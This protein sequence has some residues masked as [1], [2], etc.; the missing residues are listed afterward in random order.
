MCSRIES[1]TRARRRA[2]SSSRVTAARPG[3]GGGPFNTARTIGR[4]GLAPAF[5]GRLSQDSFGDQLRARLDEDGVT[6]AVPQPADV[7]TTLAIVDIDAAGAPP[8]PL[9]PAGTP[10]APPEDPLLT[11]PPPPGPPPPGPRAP[12]PWSWNPSRPASSA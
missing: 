12:W 3:P 2:T 6:L 8:D 7:P 4:L 1:P 9:Y 5:L 11:P 10:A